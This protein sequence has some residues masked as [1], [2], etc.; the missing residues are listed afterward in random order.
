MSSSTL[1]SGNPASFVGTAAP[2]LPAQV[3]K[4]NGARAAFE[5]AKIASAIQRAGAATGEFDAREAQRLAEHVGRVLAHRHVLEPPGHRSRP[6]RRRA[7]A[8]RQRLLHDRPCLHRPSRPPRAHSR[9]AANDRRRR[10]VRRRV[11]GE[12]GLARQRQRQPGVFAGRP[13]PQRLGQGRRQLLAVARLRAG[14]RRGAPQRR[15]AHPRP[16]HARRLLRRLVAA[17]AAARGAERRPRQ[18][19]GGPTEAHGQRGRADRQLPGHAAERVGGRAGVLVVRHVHGAVHPQGRDDVPGGE[20]VHPGADLQPERAVA[21]GHADAVHEPD[22]RLGVS[23]RPPRPDPGDRRAGDAVHVRRP[24]ARD[25]HDQPR[26]HGSDDRRRR[27]RPGVHVPDPHLQHHAGLRLGPSELRSAVRDDRA[28]RP[29]VLPEFPEFGTEAQHDPLDVLPAAARS[30]RVAEAGQRA[31]RL[32]RADRL[33]RRGHDQLRAA[34][35]TSSPA[36]RPDWCGG[37]TRC[38]ITRATAS[39]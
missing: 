26:V 9:R 22:V 19:G 38:S 17:P 3:I 5:L 33:A 13:H 20:A 25:G 4:R 24:P 1:A 14:D 2:A 35:A 15:R 39:R 29:A 34:R 6:G 32:G 10:G 31:L 36:T 12:E 27:A 7:D 21:L 30:H 18:G 8:C 11:P 23:G 16:R 37:S 28:L